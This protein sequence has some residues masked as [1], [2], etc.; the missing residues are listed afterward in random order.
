MSE[1]SL[2]G[3]LTILVLVMIQAVITLGYATLVNARA[4]PLRDLAEDGDLRARRAISLIT[5]KSL[6]VTY[7]LISVLLAFAIASLTVL[8]VA[9]PLLDANPGWMPGVIYPLA[10]LLVALLVVVVGAIVPE[11]VGTVYANS[12]VLWSAYF[13]RLLVLICS[14]LVTLILSASRALSAL[15]KSSSVVNTITEEEIMTL[16]DAGHTGGTIEEEEKDMIYSVLQLDQTRVSEMMVPRID[17]MAVSIND[18]LA[19]AWQTFVESGYS[20]IPVYGDNLDDIRG[21]LYAKDLLAHWTNGYDPDRPITSLMRRAYFVPES[22]RADELLKEL[23]ARKVHMAIVVDEYGG[24]AG[25]VTIENI[26]EEI[27][28]DIQDEYDLNEEA[29]YEQT[30]PDEYIVDASIDLDDFNELLDVDLPT[31]DSDTLA[32]HIYS[33]LGRVPVVG[34]KID[35]DDLLIE[36]LS[37]DGRRIRKLQVI[38]KHRDDDNDPVRDGAGNG[39]PQPS[40]GADKGREYE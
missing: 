22:K 40:P 18:T 2:S 27:I 8:D 35:D 12:L 34:E 37:V 20:R 21:L 6:S 25:L 14:P 26:I 39:D 11:A 1:D 30:G 16:V 36:V 23:Q 17:V 19:K 33:V 29:E 13:M 32:G 9:G 28:G 24:T 5:S 3:L 15:F 7:Q 38:R 10:L 4:A 31:D